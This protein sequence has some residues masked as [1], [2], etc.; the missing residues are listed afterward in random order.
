MNMTRLIYISRP[1]FPIQPGS[2]AGPL[3][4][5][6]AAGRRHNTQNAISGILGVELNRFFQILEGP[7]E[8][9]GFTYDKIQ[10][11]RRHS[12]VR[13]VYREEVSARHFQDWAIGFATRTYLPPTEPLEVDFE[14][15]SPEA[16]IRR[17]KILRRYGVIAEA[18]LT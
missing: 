5:I 11:D 12:D 6:V 9:V 7:K 14:K 13:L 15:A 2:F 16:I 8:D 1:N 17:G 10:Q 4:K 3:G 18:G